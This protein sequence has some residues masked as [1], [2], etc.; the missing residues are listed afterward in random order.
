MAK[1]QRFITNSE[2][3][4][5]GIVYRHEKYGLCIFES[6]SNMGVSLAIWNHLI[7]YKWYENIDSISWRRLDMPNRAE[8]FE[9]KVSEFVK[10]NLHKQYGFS[11]GKLFRFKDAVY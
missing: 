4:H 11:L 8:N 6:S 1:V 10:V 2:C 9:K 7:R 5:I 3:D